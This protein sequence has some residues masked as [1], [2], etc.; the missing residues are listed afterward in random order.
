V[1]SPVSSIRSAA[2]ATF[3]AFRRAPIRWRLAV[4]SALLTLVILCAFATAIGVLTSGQIRDDFNRQVASAAD[5]LEV[6]LRV[7]PDLDTRPTL[8]AYA[9]STSASVQLV[10]VDGDVVKKTP[11]WAPALGPPERS[12]ERKNYRVEGRQIFHLDTPQYTYGDLWVLYARPLDDVEST[13]QRVQ[14]FL[15][16]GVLS[17][18]ALALVAGLV[19]ARRA[20]DPIAQLT[21]AAREIGRTQDPAKRVPRPDGNDEVAELARTL[22]GMLT[23]L[24]ASRS[25]TEAALTRQREFVADA[26][27]ELRTPLTSVLANLELLAETLDGERREAAQSALRSTRRMRRLVADLLLLARADAR[28]RAPHAPTDVGEVVMEAAGELG[29]FAAG[30]DLDIDAERAV[31]DGAK[32]ELHRLVLNLLENAVRHTPSGTEV[33]AGVHRVDGHVVLTVEDDGPGIPPELGDRVFERFVRG[34]G[35]RGGSFGLGLSIVRAVAESHGG[36][37]RLES[38]TEN[39]TQPAHGT[40]F[41]VTLP[42]ARG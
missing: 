33:R 26:S 31:V 30:H 22:D 20:M 41:V 36:Q 17:G 27:H 24:D 34:Q 19:I 35:D 29:P 7:E 15:V 23:A 28:R 4:S 32:D 21:A 37:V 5:D 40:R 12:A 38:P 42:A 1:V 8:N 11:D 25:A 9:G 14:L 39:G 10:E 6:R 13:I 3:S 2:R 18:T 16:L